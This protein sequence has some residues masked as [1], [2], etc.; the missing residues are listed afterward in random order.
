MKKTLLGLALFTSSISIA[1]SVTPDVIATAGAHF[2]IPS[3]Q[4][5]W[6]LGEPVTQTLSN[7]SGQLTQGFQQSNISVVGISDYD[8][9]Y[10]V[11]AFPNPTID[12]VRIK[13][14]DNVSDG[15]INIVDPTGKIIF[16]KEITET[17]FLL[18]FAP[19]SQGTY[20]LNFT[21]EDGVLLHT[22]RLQKIN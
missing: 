19:Y 7:G 22:I 15:L 18:D 4:I 12:V 8:F 20:F 10:S 11:T 5:S 9:S 6:T 1:Q 16:E 17:E 2:A 3:I 21:N 13:L 14:S